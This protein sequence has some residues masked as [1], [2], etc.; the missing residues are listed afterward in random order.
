MLV[1]YSHTCL[2]LIQS[3]CSSWVAA[4]PLKAHLPSGTWLTWVPLTRTV[5]VTTAE[6]K[7]RR[8]FL[9]LLHITY[10]HISLTTT[11]HMALPTFT[12]TGKQGSMIF[13]QGKGTKY[14]WKVYHSLLRFLDMQTSLEQLRSMP[15]IWARA[16]RAEIGSRSLF[17]LPPNALACELIDLYNGYRPL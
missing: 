8:Q 7:D 17:P 16:G 13:P 2:V 1:D 12:R 5:P 6:V 10:P 9:K 11:S 4:A 15:R 14:L 3:A